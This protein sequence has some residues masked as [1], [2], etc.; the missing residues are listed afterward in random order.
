MAMTEILLISEVAISLALLTASL[1]NAWSIERFACVRVSFLAAN[2]I[3][4]TGSILEIS[5]I[6]CFLISLTSSFV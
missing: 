4:I 5:S 6:L 2:L 3:S 1:V